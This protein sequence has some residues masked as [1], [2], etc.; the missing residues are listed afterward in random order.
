MSYDEIK[1]KIVALWQN[2]TDE[3]ILKS[4]ESKQ[5]IEEVINH[6]DSGK[7]K[8]ADTSNLQNT[9]INEWVKQ[10][11]LL[12]FMT[13]NSSLHSDSN[14]TK[15]FD[16]IPLKFQNWNESK[17]VNSKIR[18]VPGCFVR[19]GAYIAQ[20]CIIMSCSFINIGAYIDEGTMIDS[21]TT[22]G[23]CVQIGKNCHISSQVCLAGVLEPLQASPVIIGDNCFIGAGS[24][25]A[26]GTIIESGAIIG[27]GTVITGST[28]IIN[29]DT[30][31]VTYGKVPANAVIVNGSIPSS[32]SDAGISTNVQCAIIV[33][34]V[35]DKSRDKTSINNILRNI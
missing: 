34:T 28:K 32:K 30:G 8:V 11:I 19:K 16:K 24:I 2:R 13:S 12:Y 4:P 14:N 1:D 26:E 7:I 25:I 6:L 3:K 27:A 22:I 18:A 35:D 33:K 15:W 5:L 21:S 9:T 31:E 10:A 23:S 29:R 20:N 17:F